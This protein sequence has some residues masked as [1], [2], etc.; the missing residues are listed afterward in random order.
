ML[1]T[2]SRQLSQADSR[3]DS[4]EGEPVATRHREEVLNTVLATCIANRGV[5]ADPE[6]ILQKGQ[7]RPDVMA[8]FRGLRC[9]I[10]G[11]V[12]DVTQAKAVVMADAYKR[13]EQGVAHLTIA[14][15]YPVALR[16]TEIAALPQALTAA[17]FEFSVLTSSGQGEWH[18]GGISEILAELRRAHETIVRDDVLQQAVDTL[19]IG[20]GEVSNALLGNKGTCDRLI[21]V[22]GIGSKPD[23]AAAI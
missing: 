7:I 17:T 16:T 4:L 3:S 19:N 12:A 14:L 8:S 5:E 11:K 20:L 21:R 23:A 22:L 15:V 6:T 13:I 1:L 9:V 10:E 2:A 18:D